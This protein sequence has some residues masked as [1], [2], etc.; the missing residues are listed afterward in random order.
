M[1]KDL[2]LKRYFTDFQKEWQLKDS[3]DM[4]ESTIFE[5]FAN[6]VILSQDELDTFVGRPELLDFCCTGGGDDAKL[7]GIGI[8]LNGQLVG[9]IDDID[10][11]V[12]KS[13]E[14]E[15]EFFMIQSKERTDFDSAALNLFGTG[16]RNFFSVPQ[17]PENENV[18]AIRELKDYIFN[19]EKVIGKLVDNPSV[20]MYYVF[21][22][23]TPND[24]HTEGIKWLIAD[25]LKNCSDSLGK[26]KVEIIDRDGIVKRC[27]NLKNDFRESLDICDIIPLTASDNERIKKAYAFT[28]KAVELLKLLTK[29]DDTLRRS[30]FNSNVRD[31]LGNKGV[32]N[33]EIEH[34]ISSEPE[35]FL[36]CNNGITIVCSNFIQ[37][38]NKLVSIDNPQ[39]VNGC[40]TCSTIFLQR[41]NPALQNVQVLVKL[42]CTE[43]SSITN[44]IVRGT[45]KQ[46]QVL[47]ESFETIKPFH[48]QLEDYFEA[49]EGP[50]RL[51]YE[52][53]NK[54]YSAI[55]TISRYQIVNLRVVTQSFVAIFL[56]KP[57]E[58]HRHESWLLKKYAEGENNRKIYNP[59]HSLY[60]YY[61]AA[62]VWYKFEDAFRRNVIEKELRPYVAHFY[63]ILSFTTGQYPL[64]ANANIQAMEKY[65]KKLEELLL[66]VHFDERVEIVKKTFERCRS[67]WVKSGKSKFSIK[68]NIEFTEH[69]TRI[70]RELFVNRTTNLEGSSSKPFIEEDE[71]W[72]YGKV[73]SV[74]HKEAHWFAFIKTD[75][76][77]ENVYFDNRSCKEQNIKQGTAVRFLMDSASVKAG[78]RYFATKVE[79]VR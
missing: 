35:M 61:I 53:R 71:Q 79:I 39:I 62:L 59:K 51:Y 31:Y 41:N 26:I 38:R 37:I 47:E 42:I 77:D 3:K 65:C 16:V 49:K 10:Q 30:L 2:I 55:P 73:L 29:D 8:K 40:Q 72:L 22:G 33:S 60:P 68:D 17:L 57:Y 48:Q 27:K 19:E 58:A 11:I 20:N 18:K 13:K 56:Q 9:S 50:V 4:P 15:V 63:Y 54:Q 52:R 45:N 36:M 78:T 76:C 5:M 67:E 74:I 75:D 23:T 34:T 12:E 46:N 1:I 64:S 24:E 44:K 69:L 43:D 7:D 14:V 21:C 6:Y 28:C 25:G 32:V 66:D 70:A